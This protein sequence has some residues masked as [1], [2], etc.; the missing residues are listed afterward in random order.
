MFR[1]K[2]IKLVFTLLLIRFVSCSSSAMSSMKSEKYL[3]TSQQDARS[4]KW[5]LYLFNHLKKRTVGSQIFS[6]KQGD[7]VNSD[8][9]VFQFQI[10]VAPDLKSDY[11]IEQKNNRVIIR[12]KSESIMLWLAYQL[13][14]KLSE[15][16][17]RINSSDIPPAF[18]TFK[19][20]CR[21][22]D[23]QYRE[24]HLGQN[25]DYERSLL[26]GNNNIDVDWG[27]WGHQLSSLANDFGDEEMFAL[28][29][30]H[31]NH[32]Q[33]CFS[34]KVL[35][36]QT[37]EF[38]L[39]QYGNG[40]KKAYRFMISPSDNNL[41][42]Q[43]SLC[44]SKGNSENNAT[45]AVTAFLN[46]LA[47]RFKNHEFYTI[48]YKTTQKAPEITL[49][50]NAGVFISTID[51]PKGIEIFEAQKETQLFEQTLASWSNKT[52]KLYLWDYAANFDDYLSPI[53]LVNGIQRQLKYFKKLGIKGIFL[54]S[55]GYDYMPFADVNAYIF[56][57]LMKDN[58]LVTEELA[59]KYITKFYPVSWKILSSFYIGQLRDFDT[60][61]KQY[62]MY[63]S[64]RE[65]LSTYIDP[66]KFSDFYETLRMTISKTKGEEKRKLKKLLTALSYSRLQI[67]YTIPDKGYSGH[68]ALQT[69]FNN[70]SVKTWLSQ[71]KKHKGHKDMVVFKEADGEISTYIEEWENLLNT[72]V[73]SNTLLQKDIIITSPKDEGFESTSMLIDKIPGFGSNYQQGWYLSSSEETE[74]TI[75]V[76]SIK[77]PS[78]IEINFLHM[79]H[80]NIYAPIKIELYVDSHPS[81]ILEFN[82][83]SIR[84]NKFQ[85]STPLLNNAKKIKLKILKRPL[86]RS[87]IALDEIS[88]K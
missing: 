52:Q 28:F 82:N 8:P 50:N 66:V 69:N 24:P 79:E 33:L 18:I 31:R 67:A 39:N 36:K 57:A 49:N 40:N 2:S 19:T 34:S 59:S 80:R 45:P 76:S 81:Q 23:F 70:N 56:S 87:S 3:I 29:D 74:I 65:N 38:I 5:A 46:N 22:F 54:N 47:Q 64:M 26:L 15:D 71:L 53:P 7:I 73:S 27:L 88:I 13:I 58:T 37:S 14:S 85:F 21:D 78:K 86:T 61:N 51:L 17:P 25:I 9:S 1:S 75:N 4:K 43:C 48:A 63:G 41:V 68:P 35:L 72:K 32:N 12:S 30:G 55:A 20:E 83:P 11:C 10:E 42:C 16:D 44:L 60:N 84:N 6:L 77:N 62:N